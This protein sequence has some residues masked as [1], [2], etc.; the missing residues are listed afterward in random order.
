MKLEI[1]KPK[2][3]KEE[4]LLKQEETILAITEEI[5]GAMKAKNIT[6]AELAEK[7]GCSRSFMTQVLSGSRNMTLATLSKICEVLELKVGIHHE[8]INH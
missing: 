6:K 3:K 5:W 1:F 2:N 8:K 7:I 4:Q